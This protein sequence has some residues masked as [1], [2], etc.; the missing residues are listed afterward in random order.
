MQTKTLGIIALTC[1]VLTALWLALLIPLGLTL[2][3][4]EQ[5]CLLSNL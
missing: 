1:L 3:R 4:S 2:A 5:S